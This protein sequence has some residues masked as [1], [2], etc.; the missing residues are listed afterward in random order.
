MKS[1][2]KIALLAALPIAF[3][4]A[5]QDLLAQKKKKAKEEKIE[6]EI[7]IEREMDD[8]DEAGKKMIIITKT[9]DD[10]GKTVIEIE[11]GE[12]KVNGKSLEDGPSQNID[13]QVVEMPGKHTM[14]W[15]QQAPGAPGAPMP[16]LAL[17]G[18]NFSFFSNDD[19]H[20][21]LG[22]VTE[23]TENGV[24]IIEIQEESAAAIA[25]LKKGDIIQSVDDTKI[26]NP[27][28]L[29]ETIRKHEPGDEV[30]VNYMR[31]NSKMSVKAELKELEH[32]FM[33]AGPEMQNLEMA[34]GDFAPRL[35]IERNMDRNFNQR[36]AWT[37]DR[38]RLG[39]SV[40][41]TEEGNGVKIIEVDEDEAAAKAGLKEE[42]II[43][44]INGSKVSTTDAVAEIVRDGMKNNKPMNF[45][46][47]RDGKKQ[48]ITV[49][50][51]K[52]LKTAD[53]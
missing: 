53:L 1:I 19:H 17:N 37:M 9:A 22:V 6:K 38:P 41:E 26:E 29:A 45:D 2:F 27:D 47:L 3:V 36:F 7:R 23:S 52:K 46:I 14:R 13:V 11:N 15:M 49:K 20:A 39:I 18:Q 16:P 30:M 34:D 44:Q 43:T 51:P 48:T 25:G 40:Q 31:G 50:I 5:P 8:S 28:Q 21:L 24:E 12:V 33:L 42:D 4:A 10:N 32:R 35:R